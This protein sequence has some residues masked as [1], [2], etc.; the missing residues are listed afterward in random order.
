MKRVVAVLGMVLLWSAGPIHAQLSAPNRAGVTMGHL[1]Y[2]VRD[3]EANKKFWI[4]LGGQPITVGA[5][6][7]I[8]FRGVLIFLTQAESLGGTEGSVLDHIGFKVP[9]VEPV[10]AALKGAGQKVQES[11]STTVVNV[12]TPAG[13]RIELFQELTENA[14][15]ILDPGR[16]DAVAERHNRPMTDPIASHHIHIYTPQG[17]DGEA[18]SWYVRMFGA[19]PGTRYHYKAADVPGMNLNFLGSADRLA[20]T[21]GRTLDHIGFE[22]KHLEAFCRTLQANGVKLDAPYAKG[23]NGIATAFL[24]DPWGTYIELTEGLDRF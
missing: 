10:L 7:V 6:E 9:R 23:R 12:F 20:P 19:T 14:R 1:H 11:R 15:F 24:T 22:V 17:A 21:K 13:D 16:T 4:A 18:R 3:V 8:K 2:N 5:T